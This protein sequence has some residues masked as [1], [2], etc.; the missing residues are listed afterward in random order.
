MAKS[1][2]LQVICL[3]KVLSIVLKIIRFSVRLVFIAANFC[4]GDIKDSAKKIIEK[5]S[6]LTANI[7]INL[8]III[9]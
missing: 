2:L 5:F 1:K 7:S 4:H 8:Q 9:V 6:S 3:A